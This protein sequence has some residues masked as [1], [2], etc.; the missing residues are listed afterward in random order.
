[1]IFIGA[2]TLSQNPDIVKNALSKILDYLGDVFFKG[3]A[4]ARNARIGFVI[5]KKSKN[6]DY[7]YVKADY[8]GALEG[9]SAFY[10]ELERVLKG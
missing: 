9:T 5:E 2:Q 10:G 6:D 8:D 3:V 7:T 1:M 4:G